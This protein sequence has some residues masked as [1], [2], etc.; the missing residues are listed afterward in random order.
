[1]LDAPPKSPSRRVRLRN[2]SG[3]NP[4]AAPPAPS[5]PAPSLD[6]SFSLLLSLPRELRE[7]IY[8]FA[9]TSAY[10][11]WW[12]SQAPIKHNVGVNLL[13]AN[14]QVYQESVSILY[15]AN[16]FLFT[17]PSDCN[18]FRVVASPASHH[19]TCVYF[20]IREK[21]LRLWTSYLG[22]KTAERSLK[23][24]LPKL[25][26]MWIFMRCGSMG[27]PAML[28]QLTHGAMAWQG[29]A[30]LAGLPPAVVVQV[31]AVQDALGQQVA[32]LQ[33]QGQNPNG[34][35]PTQVGEATGEQDNLV[36]PPPPPHPAMPFVQFQQGG[37]PPHHQALAHAHHHPPPPPPPPPP[38]HLPAGPAA[39][40]PTVYP[41]Q[42][43][44]HAHA[45]AQPHTLY[46]SFL[47]F[48]RAMGVES[49]CLSLQE[50]RRQDTEVKI[51]CI[52][53][54]P[55][56]EVDRLCRMYPDELERDRHGDARTRFRK[57][58]G[59]EVSLEITGYDVQTPGVGH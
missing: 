1:M 2:P 42:P 15:S 38:P 13:Q 3:S 34:T 47:R 51:V 9:L 24:D 14:K 8:T 29:A 26:H 31:Q 36:P 39:T 12:P 55:R 17:H 7:R 44:A 49:L 18:I 23:V 32:A 11:F 5:L 53:R 37:L 30:G 22:S 16:K 28:G 57:L 59:T 20:R 21:D 35:E 41:N 48:E 10:P 27:T 6:P 43:H 4:V 33:H 52:M 19:I 50:T 45:H 54:I 58:H 46:T 25:K 56:R 40:A